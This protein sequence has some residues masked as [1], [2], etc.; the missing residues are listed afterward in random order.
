M[1]S[2]ASAKPPSPS[3]ST[4]PKIVERPDDAAALVTARS[5]GLDVR[6]TGRTTET[7]EFIAHPD[8]RITAKVSAAAVRTK[9]DGKWT[10]I[11][12]NLRLAADGSVQ[13]VAD[14]LH[15]RISGARANSGELA[16]IGSG[17]QRLALGW[18]GRLPTPVL[19]GNRATYPDVVAGID[20]VVTATRSGFEQFVVVKSR[21]AVD[22]LPKL[23]LPLTGAGLAS[24]TADR[25]GGL[26]LHDTKGRRLGT[27]PVAEMWDAQRAPGTGE[28]TRR[29]IIAT[30]RAS[31]SKSVGRRIKS[32]TPGRITLQVR[33]NAAWLKN[34]ATRFPVTI[35]P[36]I[37][38]LTTSFDTYVRQDVTADRSGAADLQLGLFAGSPAANAHAF[39]NW[40]VAQLA[41]KQIT[42]ASVYF[43]SW[44]SNTCTPSS[45]EIWTTGA[46]SSATRWDSQPT[47]LNYEASSTQTKGYSAACDDGWV[48]ID[49]TSFFQRAATAGQSTAY[50][51]L[52]ATEETTTLG[53]K[54]FRSRNADD[55]DQVPYA[56]ITYNSYPTV[57]VRSTTPS[58]ACVTGT[59]RP[60]I[61]KTTPQLAAAVTDP[62]GSPVKAEFEWWAV[63]GTNKLGSAMSDAAASGSTL[64]VTVAAGALTDGGNFKWRVRGDDGLTR[65]SWSSFCEFTVDTS[66][67]NAP[68]ISSPQYPQDAW[69]GDANTAGDFTFS[70][71][72]SS[73]VTAYDYSLDVQTLGKV[74]NLTT[75]GEPAT[76]KITPMTAG[77]H[78]LYARS[79]N[80][81]GTVSTTRVYPFRVGNGAV[82]SPR[83]GDVSGAKVVLGSAATPSFADV[84]YQWRRASSD[85]WTTIPA[86]HVTHATGGTAVT[87]PVALSAGAAPKLNWDVA[88]T[89]ASVDAAGIPR[90][91][92]LQVRAFFNLDNYGANAEHVKFLFDRNL[93]SAET[94]DV[95]PG[96]VNLITGNLQLAQTD[97]S[98]ADLTLSR[99]LN[100]RQPGGLDPLFGPG[101]VSGVLP[102]AEAPYTRLTV[103]GSLVQI[104]LPDQSSVGFT[105][106]G[107]GTTF[108]PQV[109]AESYRLAFSST[110][111]TYTLTD[112]SGNVVTFGRS[113]TDPA[114]VYVP[115]NVVTPGSGTAMTYSW[116]KV[117]VDGQDIMRPTRLL[118]PVA[119]GVTCTTL[120]RGCKALEFRY[121]TTT[122]AT[123]TADGTWGAYAGRIAEV[124]YTAWDPDLSTPAMRSVVMARYAFDSTGRLRAFWDPRLDYTQDGAAKSMRL[125]FEYDGNGVLTSATPAGQPPWLFTYTT[126]SDDP[127]IGRLYKVTRS[128]LSAGTSV[129]TVVYR[130]PVSGTGAPYDQSAA[131][132]SRWSQTEPPVDATAV[133]PATQVPTGNPS[134]GTL[135]SNYDRATVTYLDANARMVNEAEPGGYLSTTWYD[136]NGNIVQELSGGNRQRALGASATDTPSAEAQLAIALSQ[137]TVYSTDGRRELENFGPE[138]DVVLPASG[139]TVRGR[140]HTRFTYD[141]G[142]PDSGGP[143]DLVTT[144]RSS[145][146]YVNAGQRVDDDVR[147]TTTRY[148]WTLR[149]VIAETTDPGGMEMTSRTAY[150]AAGRVTVTTGPAGGS[151]D[152]TPATRATVYY[153]NAV[154]ETYAECGGRAEWAGLVCRVQPGGGADSG[155]ELLVQVSTYDLYGQL[156]TKVDKNSGGTRRTTTIKYDG[157]G[158]PVEHAIT[159]SSGKALDKT[160]AVYDAATG[161]ALR[162]Q[163]VNAAGAVT[164]EIVRGY[165]ALGRQISYKDADG[166]ISTAGYD[167]LGRVATQN[168]G[169]ATRTYTYDGGSERRGLP[170]AVNDTQAGE[171]TVAYDADG[172]VVT[173]SW[174]NGV[175]VTRAYDEIG[176][177]LDQSYARPGCGQASCGLFSEVV[178]Y[179]VHNKQ[180]WANNTFGQHTYDYDMNGRMTL[181]K[182][183]VGGSCTAR[184]YGFDESS[185]RTSTKT[186]AQ[187]ADGKCQTATAAT[188]KS[189]SYDNADRATTNGYVY[190]LLGRTTTLPSAE[191]QNAA[192]NVTIGYYVNDMVSTVTQ[193]GRTTDY[194]VDV[195][196]SRTRFWTD[197]ITGTAVQS[198]H[199]YADDE[200]NPTW[201]QETATRY[202]RVIRGLGG[203]AAIWNSAASQ[204]DW[205]I[206]NMHGDVVASISGSSAGLT[207]T[208]DFDEYGQARNA[209]EVGKVRYGW[210]GAQQRAADAPAGIMVMGVRLYNPTSGR[211][212]SVDPIYGG[213]SNNYEYSDGDP[214]NKNDL[215]GNMSCWKT[216]TATTKWYYWWGG[217][218][219]WRGSLYFRCYISD[220]DFHNFKRFGNYYD[221][222]AIIFGLV[223]LHAFSAAFALAASVLKDWAWDNYDD[224]C[225]DEE[226]GATLKFRYRRYYNT[227]WQGLWSTFSYRGGYCNSRPR[228]VD[229]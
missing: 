75:A 38:A 98:V 168:D 151:V 87:W 193:N 102:G 56:D 96:S 92:P 30:E 80:A 76:V 95:E 202:T 147:T 94:A 213:S 71:N 29:S 48:S 141:E 142:A 207:S 211:F 176:N 27:M 99:T 24:S 185:N 210:H 180:Q 199:H 106:T 175:V 120:V 81:A 212:L 206:S 66:I 68:T 215:S 216:S 41:G 3:P 177:A 49:G 35:D 85:T 51:G 59:D 139:T 16:S 104:G 155:P 191:T 110:S 107:S 62:E 89:L 223:G 148:D 73:D 172:S 61:N 53:S 114:G 166:N 118:A 37:N 160:R 13:P 12:L 9:R 36:Q 153:T 217:W 23:D 195:L 144:Q 65:G 182:D 131:Q 105:R 154:N 174:P 1:P 52:R 63:T 170:T 126:L 171:F 196:R 58:S 78:A 82:T 222:A 101:W 70:P 140:A 184:R 112:E 159:A 108:E 225:D 60:K 220:K 97:V 46:A 158:R 44:W 149:D 208:R 77:W 164:A 129:Q 198:T 183:T 21:D 137:V 26:V 133:F 179:D 100:T 194:T 163:T 165:D 18:P 47:W 124:A 57:G 14:S 111:N 122:S 138:H 197:N 19:A 116:Q 200:D 205:Q 156:R 88:A 113:S 219:G 69:G 190:D 103:Y 226:A 54:L 39:V 127:A 145:V 173:E 117:T 130:V 150:D 33:P 167:L 20:L 157:A 119:D 7:S 67:V 79:R 42:A 43:W 72:G 93:A 31:G 115:T 123:G 125:T 218:G 6:I 181:V 4:L 143:F 28:P 45:W 146:S 90:D 84:T 192:G 201:T 32:D 178:G 5:T 132:T 204:S 136:G 10:P 209:A 169:K 162:S 8:G 11:D 86:A 40:P 152:T 224:K 186:F 109:G 134:A 91:G 214:V 189:S 22:R 188:S 2:L 135:P 187:A 83:P 50:M 161:L 55:T 128:A 203:M 121:S 227:K 228:W 64:G 17:D 229:R 34:P 74:V 15:L 25:S 221:R